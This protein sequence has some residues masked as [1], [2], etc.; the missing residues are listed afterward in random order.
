[1]FGMKKP[2]VTAAKTGSKPSGGDKVRGGGMGIARKKQ[3]RV[4]PSSDKNNVPAP[5]KEYV[6]PYGP[7]GSENKGRQPVPDQ[8]GYFLSK[9][10]KHHN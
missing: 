2:A 10:G 3:W 4:A 5:V 6:E 7:Y 8:D 1:M 9:D